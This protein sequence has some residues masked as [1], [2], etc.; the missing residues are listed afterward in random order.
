MWDKPA[1]IDKELGEGRACDK[2]WLA[3]FTAEFQQIVVAVTAPVDDVIPS[4]AL[5]LFAEDGLRHPVTEDIDLNGM[6]GENPSVE[7]FKKFLPLP[8]HRQ[9]SGVGCFGE[10]QQHP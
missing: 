6:V 1:R 5:N 7:E 2:V 9:R 8:S 3:I 4:G 10:D